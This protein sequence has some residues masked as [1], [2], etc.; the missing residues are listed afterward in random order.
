MVQYLFGSNTDAVFLKEIQ[1][2]HETEPCVHEWTL[3]SQVKKQNKSKHYLYLDM[4]V[5][6]LLRALKRN[7]AFAVKSEKEFCGYYSIYERGTL[8]HATDDVV[9]SDE[10]PLN[11]NLEVSSPF[12][13]DFRLH[14]KPSCQ[15]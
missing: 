4:D 15:T 1:I 5:V 10:L 13:I 9:S 11:N 3:K 8:F 6:I 2:G 12:L 14:M 7:L